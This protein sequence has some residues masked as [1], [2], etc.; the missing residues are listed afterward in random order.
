MPLC[1]DHMARHPTLMALCVHCMP[2]H[3]TLMSLCVHH[4]PLT[5]ITD[6]FSNYLNVSLNLNVSLRVILPHLPG[7]LLQSPAPSG[8]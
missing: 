1:V 2:T 4:A 3:P 8:Q 7:T 5:D 6:S